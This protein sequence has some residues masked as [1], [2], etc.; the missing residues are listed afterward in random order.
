MNPLRR[1][2]GYF[3]PDAGRIAVAFGFLVLS[4]ALALI[5]P[6]PLAVMVDSVLGTKELPATIAWARD[7][8][9]AGMLGLL[10]GSILIL[11]GSQGFFTAIQNFLSIRVG[12]RGLA[13]VRRELFSSLQRLSMRFQSG[14]SQGDVIYRASWDTYSFQ[15]LFQQGFFTLAQAALT[16]GLM[17]TIMAQLNGRLTLATASSVPIVLLVMRLFA[18]GIKKRSLEAHRTDSQLTGFIHQNIAAL[19]L[20]Q[21]YTREEQQEKQ[22]QRQAAK[23]L[24]TRT[25]QHA[26]EV[27]YWFSIAVVFGLAASGI[28]WLGAL[29]VLSG[30]LTTGELL[31]FLAYLTQLYEPLN[32]LSHLGPTISDASAGVQRVFELMD[33]PREVMDSP[34]AHPIALVGLA[35]GSRTSLQQQSALPTGKTFQSRGVVRLDDVWFAYEPERW[36]LREIQLTL[37]PGKTIALIGPSGSGKSTLLNLI[38]RFYDPTRGAVRLDGTDVRQ[39]R[40]HDLRAQIAVVFQEPILLPGTVLENIA[41]G[42]EGA[43][44]KEIHDAAQAANADRF[45]RNL[46]QGYQTLVGEGGTRLSV[47]ERQRISLARAFLKNAPVLLLDEP[48]SPLDAEN[49]ALVMESVVRLMQNRSTLIVAHRLATLK[50]VHQIV[51]LQDGCLTNT[52]SV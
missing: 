2:L 30:R 44:E 49:E 7:W 14:S 20:I 11:H 41:F 51:Q 24:D 8:E 1:A 18:G 15:T 28:T 33:S 22:F 13:R 10:A 26:A 37:E 19:P 17:L 23:A 34:D 31:V 40:L 45:I 42:R 48:T 52:C 43:L 21:S 4:T 29:E 3:R 50:F 9:R 39:F 5:K 35:P 46:P 27:W 6:W 38:P 36:I 12:L 47:G 16:L 25:A 32:Q